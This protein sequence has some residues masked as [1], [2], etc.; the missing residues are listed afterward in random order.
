MKKKDTTEFQQAL[1]ET[2]DLV[3]AQQVLD[4]FGDRWAAVARRNVDQA[5]GDC[6]VREF[7]KHLQN[8]IDSGSAE[9]RMPATDNGLLEVLANCT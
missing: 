9:L 6:R 8:A 4:C 2:G 5:T 7:K 3:L 1:F